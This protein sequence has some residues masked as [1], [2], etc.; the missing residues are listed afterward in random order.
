MKKLKQKII[1][2]KKFQN[3]YVLDRI[4][5]VPKF[6]IVAKLSK[7]NH[8]AIDSNNPTYVNGNIAYYFVEIDRE[9]IGKSLTFN[10]NV[11]FPLDVLDMFLNEHVTRDIV[12]KHEHIIPTNWKQ[13]ILPFLLGL[14]V[15]AFIVYLYL[16]SQGTNI[17]T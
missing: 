7:S 12:K 2:L 17:L 10:D 3:Q 9:N 11:E 8:V 16:Q 14:V 1:V 6:T 4:I 5:T 13:N 15:G